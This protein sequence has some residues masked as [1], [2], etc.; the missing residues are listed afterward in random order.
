M[1]QAPL[2]PWS[3]AFLT[4]EELRRLLCIGPMQAERY[5]ELWYHACQTVRQSYPFLPP[6]SMHPKG[7][8]VTY[9]QEQRSMRT[10][11]P[12]AL[13]ALRQGLMQT[14]MPPGAV[15]ARMF[16][17]YYRSKH[18][19]VEWD[20]RLLAA[21]GCTICGIHEIPTMPLQ[22]ALAAGADPNAILGYNPPYLVR[23]ADLD[24]PALYFALQAGNLGQVQ[25]LLA[26]G[27]RTTHQDRHGTTLQE[28]ARIRLVAHPQC[29]AALAIG[30]A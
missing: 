18:E 20:A 16:V 28:Y 11:I 22:A 30:T 7:W 12:H 8:E 21:A 15:A 29:L 3:F 10:F 25:E 9:W 5:Q 27:A 19:T 6:P 23:V 13:E 4:L 1:E 2:V 17:R 24:K 26:A 14:R